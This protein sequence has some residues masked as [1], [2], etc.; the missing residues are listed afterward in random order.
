MHYNSKRN[1]NIHAPSNFV[2]YPTRIYFE[3][4]RNSRRGDVNPSQLR[5]P[6][7]HA[8]KSQQ[9]L[10]SARKIDFTEA[11]VQRERKTK[12][13][14]VILECIPVKNIFEKVHQETFGKSGCRCIILGQ[15]LA[16]DLK[17]RA[18]MIGIVY[19]YLIFHNFMEYYMLSFC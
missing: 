12:R 8:E 7:T 1:R 17:G 11:R 13:R 5:P 15:Y 9:W 10:R 6:I 3:I 16:I 4:K 2:K 18:V 14:I 19:F